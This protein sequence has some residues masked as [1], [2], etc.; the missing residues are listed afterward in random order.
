MEI[1][2][3]EGVALVRIGESREVVECRLGTPV[4]PGRLDRAI[5]ETHPMLVLSYGDLDTVELVELAYSGDGGEE[6]WFD[7][8]QLTYRFMDDVLADLA[9]RGYRYEETGVGYRF[10]PGFALFS[11]G[12][13]SARDLDPGAGADDQRT[14]CEGV[15][16]APY[17]YFAG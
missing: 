16:V 15:S 10:E 17:E 3:G 14:I 12:S 9:A 5:Y 13:R 8:V 6:A 4:H 11:M 2:P 1:L 7:G